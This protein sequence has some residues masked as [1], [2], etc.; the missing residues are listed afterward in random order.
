[1]RPVQSALVGNPPAERRALAGNKTELDQSLEVFQQFHAS[2]ELPKPREAFA[3]GAGDRAH[4]TSSGRP[5]IT[6][7]RGW[8]RGR[9]PGLLA[10]NLRVAVVIAYVVLA[11]SRFR[12]HEM[13]VQ[14]EWEGRRL[15]VPLRQVK[16]LRDRLRVPADLLVS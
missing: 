3:G 4:Q 14:V 10:D 2:F 6:S 12:G 15:A 11:V 1:M 16:A 7:R 5:R 13:F 9:I 8:W